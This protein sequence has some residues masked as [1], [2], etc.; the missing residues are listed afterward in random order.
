MSH[1]RSRVLY[2][3]FGAANHLVRPLLRS[4]LHPLVSRRLMLLTY[5]GAK[6]GR[7]YAI[8]VGYC[9]CEP[10][11]VWA[12][13]AR[14]GWA[15]NFRQPC[16]V[17]LLLRGQE[18]RAQAAVVEEPEQVAQMVEEL[19]RHEGPGAVRDPFLGLP[20]DRHPT[21]EEALLVADRARAVR[22]RPAEGSGADGV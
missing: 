7:T 17:R 6:S 21:H 4:P 12:F 18:V 2:G 16:T 8:P 5:E 19:V 14:T 1:R 22:F 3:F 10:G 9:R 20:R 15:S 13:S 11:E